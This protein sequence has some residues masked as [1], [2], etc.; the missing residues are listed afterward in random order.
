MYTFEN[1]CLED[2][3]LRLGD[4]ATKII[5]NTKGTVGEV[6]DDLKSLLHFMDGMDPESEY[7]K[8]LEKAVAEVKADEKWRREY[9]VLNELVREKVRLGGYVKTVTAVR[10]GR[11]KY[12]PE[13]IADLMMVQP[14]TVET[15]ISTID[16]HP[17]WDDEEVAENLNFE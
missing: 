7:T 15:I 11:G 12:T 10:R 9:M 1:R 8:D 4:D 3:D 14:T 16:A 17:E 5:L 2:F 13:A 6:S